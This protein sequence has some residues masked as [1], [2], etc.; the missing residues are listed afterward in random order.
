MHFGIL[1]PLHNH[2]KNQQHVQGSWEKTRELQSNCCV[3]R[4]LTHLHCSVLPGAGRATWLGSDTSSPPFQP[5]PG[6]EAQPRESGNGCIPE[7]NGCCT[8]TE[9]RG[10][11]HAPLSSQG[12]VECLGGTLKFSQCHS[13]FSPAQVVQPGL[14]HFQ[15]WGIPLQGSPGGFHPNIP[16]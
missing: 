5:C 4:E 12:I 7:P 8:G 9:P 3:C 13:H 11:P 6:H 2:L 10:V 15:G 14:G 1:L 16:P